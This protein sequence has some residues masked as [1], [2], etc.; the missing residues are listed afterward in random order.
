M[1]PTDRVRVVERVAT[2][3]GVLVSPADAARKI[4]GYLDRDDFG[5]TEIDDVR[6]P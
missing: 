5:D 4:L 3:D 2:S 1:S 6:G